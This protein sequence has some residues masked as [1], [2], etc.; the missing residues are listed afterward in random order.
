MLRIVKQICL[1][2]S[3]LLA[4]AILILGA[5]R[6]EAPALAP[7]AE[8]ADRV[9]IEKGARRMT[10]WRD[11]MPIGT[12]PIALGFTP[13]G[14]KEMEGDGKTPE[15]IYQIDR[16]NDRSAFHLS[17]GISYPDA[18]DRAEARAAGRD[19]GGDIFIHG[20][21]NAWSGP[22]IPGDWTAGCVAVS[23]AEM[24][25]VW[26]LVPIGTPVEIRP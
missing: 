4:G 13:Q 18:R 23:N 17:L 16:R 12:Y 3:A 19:P 14:D 25:E 7:V 5:A 26:R 1:L 6:A 15:G 2:A 8:R 11:G 21:P 9:V 22:K 24:R 20:Q 10:L